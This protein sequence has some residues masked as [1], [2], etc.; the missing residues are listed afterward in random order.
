MGIRRNRENATG[1]RKVKKPSARQLGDQTD[2][3]GNLERSF[4]ALAR[5]WGVQVYSLD[6]K[7][8]IPTQSIRLRCQ[9]PL[10]EF[11]EICKVCPPN[12]PSVVE[13]KEALRDYSKAFLIVLRE[14]IQD[15]ER[16]RKDFSAELKLG[17]VVSDLE[18][19]AFQH[20]YL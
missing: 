14:R 18:R 15:V 10:C 17:E 2:E 9:V 19:T 11:Y 6:V 4:K 12:I 13:F 7:R 16:Y 1:L 5:K 8:I 3:D 20:G